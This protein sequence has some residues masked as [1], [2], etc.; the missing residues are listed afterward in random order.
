MFTYSPTRFASSKTACSS[1]LML[2][3][4][5]AIKGALILHIVKSCCPATD[6]GPMVSASSAVLA[7]RSLDARLASTMLWHGGLP[8]REARHERPSRDRSLARR[9]HQADPG[10][11]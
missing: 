3:S 5:A 11:F 10:R 7:T 8:A 1:P 2:H 4:K 9:S 6:E